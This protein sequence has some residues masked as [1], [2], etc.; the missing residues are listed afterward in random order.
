M[1]LIIRHGD[2]VSPCLPWRDSDNENPHTIVGVDGNYSF[3]P[4]D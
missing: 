1:H 3:P 2:S 4:L